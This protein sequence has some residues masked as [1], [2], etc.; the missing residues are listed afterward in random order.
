MIHEQTTNDGTDDQSRKEAGPSPD[1]TTDEEPCPE[2]YQIEEEPDV[3][4]YHHESGEL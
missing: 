1:V 4:T 3:S 2:D